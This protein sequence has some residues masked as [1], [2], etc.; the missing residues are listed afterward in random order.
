[1]ERIVSIKNISSFRGGIFRIRADRGRL[2]FVGVSR[3]RPRLCKKREITTFSG[4]SLP[5]PTS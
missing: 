5:F 3:F 4:V 1:M 2:Q